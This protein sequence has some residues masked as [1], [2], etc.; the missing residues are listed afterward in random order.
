MA[1]LMNTSDEKGY[2]TNSRNIISKWGPAVFTDI[3]QSTTV[4]SGK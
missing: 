2:G 4:L 1:A 3:L